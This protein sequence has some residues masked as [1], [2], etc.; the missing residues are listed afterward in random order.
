MREGA[1][2][3]LVAVAR[4]KPAASETAEVVPGTR[5]TVRTIP[6]CGRLTRSPVALLGPLVRFRASGV[7]CV[8]A[9][10]PGM[11]TILFIF[12]CWACRSRSAFP[13]RLEASPPGRVRAVTAAAC[14]EPVLRGQSSVP[15]AD[16][17]AGRWALGGAPCRAG[18]VGGFFCI[19]GRW[20]SPSALRRRAVCR[21]P[22]PP[23][24]SC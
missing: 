16:S 5:G 24:G 17:D 22:P 2:S 6:V 19:S 23:T 1:F 11:G 20:T 7:F 3:C 4:V 15:R 12:S 14:S 18:R 10:S 21:V 13:R 8:D 9:M